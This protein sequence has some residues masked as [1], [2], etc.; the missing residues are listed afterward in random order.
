MNTSHQR[1][2]DKAVGH[3]FGG[4]GTGNKP[5]CALLYIFATFIH[6]ASRKRYREQIKSE[7]I[8]IAKIYCKEPEFT[9]IQ[10]VIHSKKIN[11]I[12]STLG[13]MIKYSA[14]DAEHT[15]LNEIRDKLGITDLF[16]PR[17]LKPSIQVDGC[18]RNSLAMATCCFHT[19][20]D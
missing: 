14:T 11:A 10:I 9:N 8:P 19:P 15:K 20:D 5:A 2:S 7:T 1:P 13:V 6:L 18:Y 3:S 16:V 17:L 12:T 4:C